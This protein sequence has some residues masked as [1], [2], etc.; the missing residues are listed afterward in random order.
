VLATRTDLLAAGPAPDEFPVGRRSASLMPR[1]TE[2]T[3]MTAT[4][5][6]VDRGT[7]QEQIDELRA[8]EKAHTREGDAIAADRR[9]LPMVEVDPTTPWSGR[10]ARFA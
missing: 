2:E 4:P 8:R 5:A 1:R 7:W 3:S 6:I 10:P 9:R